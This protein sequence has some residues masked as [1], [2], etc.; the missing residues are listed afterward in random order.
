MRILV[1]G[2]T[3]FLSRAVAVEAVARGH[4]VVCACRGTSGR[5][6][7]GA[8]HVVLDRTTGDWP[9]LSGFDAVVDVSRTPSHVRSAVAALP[10]A[11]W[12]FVS[13]CSVYADHRALGGTPAT[14]P[15]IDAITEDVDWTSSPEAYGGMKVACEQIVQDGAATSAVVRPGL[16][17]GPGDPTGRFTYWPVRLAEPGPVLAP[18]ADDV[19]QTIDVRDLAAWVVHA[20]ETRL[21]GVYD[22]VGAAT[23][24]ADFLAEVA[25]GVADT[26][27]DFAWS[28]EEF[29]ATH[30]VAAWH[31]PRSL[32]V[33]VPGKDDRGF[34]AHD[35][36]PSLAAG[37]R[38]R[39]LADTARDTLAWVRSDPDA[40][41]TG[42]TVDEERAVLAAR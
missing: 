24:R 37:L 13:T 18:P 15:L 40:V 6:P 20:A 42:L 32:P 9:A 36:A 25:R 30:E 4:D 41:V 38:L 31:G 22:G 17:A 12:V 23:L 5:V 3:V 14:T 35:V 19:V 16:I 33:W 29:L 8:E 28:S 7:D 39:P 2:G 10:E 26:V 27:P 11:H 21:E 34:M 1:L